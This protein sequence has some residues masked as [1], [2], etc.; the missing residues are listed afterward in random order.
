MQSNEFVSEWLSDFAKRQKAA[1][2]KKRA[3]MGGVLAQPEME[4]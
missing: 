2:R 1:I 3:L 4:R